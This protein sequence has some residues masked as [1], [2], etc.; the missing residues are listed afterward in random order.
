MKNILLCVW[1]VG[2]FF[3][4]FETMTLAQKV[5]PVLPPRVQVFMNEAWGDSS[6]ARGL[7]IMADRM[8]TRDSRL[9]AM[10]LLHSDRRKLKPNEMRQFLAEVTA[11]VKDEAADAKLS[12]QAV[13]TMGNLTLTMEE[14][15]QLNRTEA[16]K[17]AV[18]L[19]NIA[20]DVQRDLA[21]RSQA[22]VVLGI[23]KISQA[24]PILVGVL[25]TNIDVPQIASPA[26]LSLMRI[27]GERAVSVLVNV[28]H[29][30]N[31]SRIFGTAAFA[32]GQI[33]SPECMSALVQNL[34]RFPESSACGAALVDMELVV[35]DALKNSQNERLTEAVRATRYL[36]REGQREH[37]IPALHQLLRAAPLAV[38]KAALERLLEEA[39]TQ[40]FDQEKRELA[41]I[42]ELINDQ[43][44]LSEYQ[45]KIR[46]R[47]SASLV[48]PS[49]GLT[50]PVF[51]KPKGER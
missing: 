6:F 5:S 49:S 22:I 35:L 32:L 51:V 27:D 17:E 30:T 21:M 45:E 11:I 2:I 46:E 50:A 31:D 23:L 36:W 19:L 20:T 1:V 10:E 18:F 47:L 25:N 44:Q 13:H 42:L 29:H 48:M 34:E 26:C 4:L 33:K 28:L 43:T 24:A 39:S 12:A 40:E 14:L 7:A 3:F 16:T 9:L 38:R 37:Y 8:E 15:G 41:A